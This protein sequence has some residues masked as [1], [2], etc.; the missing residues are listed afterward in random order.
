MSDRQT[1]GL[2]TIDVDID[3][4]GLSFRRV[5]LPSQSRGDMG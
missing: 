1:K 3:V 2:E 4:F 5:S